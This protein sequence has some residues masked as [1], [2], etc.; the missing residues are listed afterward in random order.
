MKVIQRLIKTNLAACLGGRQLQTRLLLRHYL[1]GVKS[2]AC[3]GGA[4]NVPIT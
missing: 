4:G 1:G 3:D 2:H